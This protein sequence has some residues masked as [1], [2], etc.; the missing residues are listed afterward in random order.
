[1]LRSRSDTR[2]GCGPCMAASAHADAVL[3]AAFTYGEVSVVSSSWGYRVTM[4]VLCLLS[5][6]GHTDE[7]IAG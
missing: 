2:L 4:E 1:M 3:S 6:F 5:P 7:A